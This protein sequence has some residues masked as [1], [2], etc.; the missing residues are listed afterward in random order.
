VDLRYPIIILI[1]IIIIL[2]TLIF[3][4]IH[5]I[6]VYKESKKKRIYK[7]KQ[8]EMTEREKIEEKYYLFYTK[9]L[10]GL[11][12]KIEKLKLNDAWDDF[13][14]L[15]DNFFKDILNITY[16]FTNEELISELEGKNEKKEFIDFINKLNT[17]YESSPS[18][19][20]LKK[21]I[22]EFHI[23]LKKK[24]K[25]NVGLSTLHP[26]H[27][28]TILIKLFEFFQKKI[29]KYKERQK[30]KIKP[31]K[32]KKQ[33]KI[34]KK[35]KQKKQKTGKRRKKKKRKKKEKN[36]KEE[37]TKTRRK[38]RGKKKK[39]KNKESKKKEKKKRKRKAPRKKEKK[40]KK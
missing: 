7:Q 34:I 10:E 9:K 2:I 12:R 33:E 8:K 13:S 39:T 20:E 25:L 19:E 6:K 40:K 29:Q 28:K 17:K 31:I 30:K 1:P 26:P 18:K 32:Q 27:K 16:E 23:I 35:T 22:L 5:S 21:L 14:E 36:K 3:F 4:V 37:K 38:K 11:N 24:P 15:V